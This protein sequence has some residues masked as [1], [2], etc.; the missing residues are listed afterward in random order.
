MF[1][2]TLTNIVAL[3]LL[4]TLGQMD[5]CDMCDETRMGPAAVETGTLATAGTLPRP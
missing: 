4:F 5:M 3:V 2:L 1:K